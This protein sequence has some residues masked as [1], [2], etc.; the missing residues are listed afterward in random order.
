MNQPTSPGKTKTVVEVLGEEMRSTVAAEP[1]APWANATRRVGELF[2]T[3]ARFGCDWSL[4]LMDV[5][6][7]PRAT[8]DQWATAVS[9]PSVEWTHTDN[10]Y[11]WRCQWVGEGEAQPEI[12]ATRNWADASSRR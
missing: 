2:V 6:P 4:T 12:K 8:C 3:L 11:V 10:G 1:S 5:Q 7:I 9:A